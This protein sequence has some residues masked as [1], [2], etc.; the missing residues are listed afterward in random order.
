MKS[1]VETLGPTQ[2]KLSVEVPFEELTPAIDAAYKKI[3][4]SVKVQG[5]RPGKVPARILDQRV[6]RPAVLE[7]AINDALPKLYTE[8]VEQ[9]EVKAVGRP[10]IDV[11]KFEDGE[12]LLF[13]A[14]V[15]VRP[16]I[17]LPAY[18]AL[19]VTVDDADVTDEQLNEQLSNLQDRFATLVAVERDVQTGDFV[20]LD[21]G[22]TLDGEQ[23]EGTQATGLSYEVGSDSLMPGVDDVLV[24]AAVGDPKSFDTDL[25][26]GEHTGR[27]AQ[28]QVTVQGVKVKQ[29]PDIDTLMQ[30]WNPEMEQ[31]LREIPFPGPEIDMHPTDYSRLVCSMVDIPCHCRP[32]GR[33]GRAP[34]RRGPPQPA[35]PR[36]TARS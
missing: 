27:T 25:Q 9:A 31:A 14:T 7:E 35:A 8:A 6:G 29:M 32:R 22:A 19:A 3:G 20:T 4:R 16:V 28:V 2:V 33:G 11:E 24:G 5:F 15:D 30:E 36:C 13:N 34:D 1:S 23:V 17:E 10:T 18:D 21:I 12:P 26:Y